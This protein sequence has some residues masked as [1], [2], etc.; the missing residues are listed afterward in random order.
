M[1]VDASFVSFH[2]C[3]VVKYQSVA[4]QFNQKLLLYILRAIKPISQSTQTTNLRHIRRYIHT[5]I[6]HTRQDIQAVL[7]RAVIR[8]S[9]GI[10]NKF[11]QRVRLSSGHT[12]D[13]CLQTQNENKDLF[14]Y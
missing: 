3:V 7:I 13:H 4:I 10:E 11:G 5:T 2:A 6:N 8:I 9:T 14:F 1:A 12:T